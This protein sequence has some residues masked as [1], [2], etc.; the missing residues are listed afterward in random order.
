MKISQKHLHWEPYVIILAGI[1]H[2]LLIALDPAQATRPAARET[3]SS[4]LWGRSHRRN[5]SPQVR[6]RSSKRLLLTVCSCSSGATSH[7]FTLCLA[8][9]DGGQPAGLLTLAN[10]RPGCNC[11]QLHHASCRLV[12]Y[13]LVAS[14]KV[15]LNVLTFVTQNG[16]QKVSQI[17]RLELE[18]MASHRQSHE[19]L[20]ILYPKF[21][22]QM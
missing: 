10:H 9:T 1:R 14:N 5:R 19:F 20:G 3:L 18:Y 8:T 12:N 7:T 15:C 2:H 13:L 17:V 11:A 6:V 22:S 4:W 21:L 16:E